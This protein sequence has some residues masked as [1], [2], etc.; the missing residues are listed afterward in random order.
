MN[1]SSSPLSCPGNL[2]GKKKCSAGKYR[3]GSGG[4]YGGQTM[5]SP[6]EKNRK[7]ETIGKLGTRAASRRDFTERKERGNHKQISG[8]RK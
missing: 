4:A 1:T 3:K 8:R 6:S 7:R 2:L 5:T